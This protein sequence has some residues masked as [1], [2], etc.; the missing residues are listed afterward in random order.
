M[1]LFSAEEIIQVEIDSLRRILKIKETIIGITEVDIW[2]EHFPK[3]KPDKK[4]FGETFTHTGYLFIDPEKN[5]TFKDLKHTIAHEVL[6][7][8]YPKAN[9][10]FIN[11]YLQHYIE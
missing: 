8:K 4:M 11:S 10:K 6:H 7:L 1:R 9:H 5:A 2:K 3:S